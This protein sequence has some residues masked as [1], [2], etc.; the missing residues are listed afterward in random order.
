MQYEWDEK[1]RLANF[2]RHEIDFAD[3]VN[4][5]WD[6]AIEARDDRFDY[7][8]ERW[9]AVGF[10]SDRLCHGLCFSSPEHKN[11]QLA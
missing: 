2:V 11:N 10:I 9:V 1:K 8:E 4:F 3:A 7:G 5:E 6:T